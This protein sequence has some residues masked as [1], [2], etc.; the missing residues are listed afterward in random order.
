MSEENLKIGSLFS[1]MFYN[2][3]YGQEHLGSIWN[4]ESTRKVKNIKENYCLIFGF[5]V[6]T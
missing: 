5:I 6:K 1:K 4:L 3:Y 2:F